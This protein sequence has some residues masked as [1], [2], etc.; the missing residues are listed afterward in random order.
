MQDERQCPSEA[1]VAREYL[2]VSRDRHGTGKSPNQQ[3]AENAKAVA[4]WGWALHPSPYRDDDRSASRYA[5]KDREN[6]RR[7]I[8]DLEEGRFEADVLVIW[9]SSRGSRRTGEWVNLIE[10]C[11][12]RGILIFVTTHRREYDPSNARDRR[13]MLEDAV[14]SEYESAK[15]SERI[16]RDV[17][18]AA[19]EGRVHGKN[20]YGYRRIYDEKTGQLSHIEPDPEQSGIVQEAAHRVLAGETYYS[21]ARSFNERSVPPR[22]PSHKPHRAHLGWT[23]AAVK[24]MLSTPAYAGK[25]QHRGA[26]VAQA[27]W[28]PLID[29]D[30]WERKLLPLLNNPARKRTNDWPARHLLTGIAVCGEC[31]GRVRV[32]KQNNGR[33][34][35]DEGGRP[36]PREHYNTYVC[37]GVPGKTGFHV[38]M[39]TTHLDQVVTEHVIARLERVD[40]IT[41]LGQQDENVDAEMR[42][43]VQEIESHRRYLDEVREHAAKRH[44]MSILFDQEDRVR[45]LIDAAQASL[46]R[47]AATDPLVIDIA[48][49]DS[50][51]ETWE[52]LTLA[53]K[54]RVV[55]ALMTPRINRVG[56]QGRGRKGVNTER[57]EPG[58]R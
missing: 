7:L 13:S 44:D 29:P 30:L 21:I 53:D 15:T 56:D 5:A 41:T 48:S 52:G 20:L 6:F 14:D 54:R 36:L 39:K 51:R 35:Y 18:A 34:K 25:R 22:R 26:I 9:E 2:R 57:V 27:V 55:R 24:S 49:A 45:P 23:P 38:A 47:L 17:Q 19:E 37:Q 28:P 12:E 33:P 58:W 43:L 10:L 8:D 3:H 32:G 11:E 16:R 42:V 4:Q 46:E 1:T 40:F 50:I 31:G